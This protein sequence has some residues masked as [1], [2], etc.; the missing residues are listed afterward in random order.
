LSGH[1]ALERLEQ[2]REISITPLARRAALVVA[3]LATLLAVADVLGENHLKSVITG[4]TRLADLHARIDL[5][6]VKAVL[7][8][9]PA[10]ATD[11]RAS[12]ATTEQRVHDDETAHSRLELAKVLLQVAIVLASACGMLGVAA[13]MTGAG[14]AGL[15]GTVLLVLGLLA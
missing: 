14:V 11:L 12:A 8:H 1:E 7:A 3:I 10:Q 9:A 15:A 5:S 2:L 4:E 6:E 13:L